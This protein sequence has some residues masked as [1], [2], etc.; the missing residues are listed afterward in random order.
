MDA[1]HR[2]RADLHLLTTEQ[3]AAFLSVGR[4]K[5]LAYVRSGDLK[6]I[7]LGSRSRRFDMDDLRAFIAK[8]KVQECPSTDRSSRRSTTTISGSAVVAIMDRLKRPPGKPRSS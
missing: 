1:D 8:R 4:K 3:A 6:Y 7:A 2:K 5:V